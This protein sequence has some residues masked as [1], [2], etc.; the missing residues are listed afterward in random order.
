MTATIIITLCILVLIAYI[1]DITS[2]KTSIPSVIL[3]LLLGFIARE[4]TIYLNIEI[5]DLSPL[6]PGLGTIGLILIVL[7]GSLDLELSKTKML[8]VK[9][10]FISALAPMVILGLLIGFYFS[11]TG[12][13]SLKDGISNALPFCVISSAIAIPSVKNLNNTK[14]T[15]IIYESSFSDILGVIFFN[16]ITFNE[17]INLFS[18][19]HFITQF[20]IMAVIAI[21]STALLS[22]LLSKINHHVKFIPIVLLLILIY[23]LSK[24]YNLPALIFILVF[25]LAVG[26]LDKLSGIRSIKI[27]RV[28]ELKQEINKFKGLV[29]EFTFLIRTLFFLLFGFLMDK[30]TILNIDTVIPAVLIV[31]LIFF[32]RAVQ[33]LL[34]K[35]ELRPILFIAPRGLITILLFISIPVNQSL[36]HVEDSLIIQ[37]IILSTLLMM[38]GLMLKKE[39]REIIKNIDDGKNG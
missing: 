37:V 32:L 22:L 29:T 38:F 2:S 30:S 9:K 27:L 39:K 36:W 15:F 20:I 3:L 1:F 21:T 14:R 31:M 19:T 4:L 5:P 7:E 8:T 33:L 35:I 6:L 18:I 12:N 25:G 23:E 34:L 17:I 24:I 28:E 13:V 26:N 11:Y 16:F 10:S